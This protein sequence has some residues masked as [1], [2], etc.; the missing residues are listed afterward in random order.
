MH[1]EL[2]ALLALIKM[3]GDHRLTVNR[4]VAVAQSAGISIQALLELSPHERIDV[5]GPGQGEVAYDLSR[6]ENSHM[7][8]ARTTLDHLKNKGVT[9]IPVTSPD[10]PCALADA[11]GPR[12]PPLLFVLGH[13]ATLSGSN[14]GIVGARRASRAGLHLADRC[15][16]VF[17]QE[18]IPVVSGG[19]AGVDTRA[20]HTTLKQGSSTIVVLAQGVLTVDRG[21]WLPRAAENDRLLVL[22]EFLPDA[23]W[24]SRRAVTRN[25]TI[26]ALSR[27]V[28]VID[29]Q[30]G[31]G[32][33]HTARAAMRMGRKLL[34]RCRDQDAD[35]ERE[36]LRDGAELLDDES[37]D[38]RD[39]LLAHWDAAPEDA[40]R[41]NELF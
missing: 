18:G 8:Y 33:M 14:A 32:S 10:Y 27:L 6:F 16:T 20:H 7:E 38:L 2:S 41:Q 35:L 17:A 25:A 23:P 40:G 34:V 15:A 37:G 36:L 30:R 5:L 26:S 4:I 21:G 31:S 1:A 12:T 29:P 3:S 22:S 19:A 9:A 39:A 24:A 28:C 11:L 13:A